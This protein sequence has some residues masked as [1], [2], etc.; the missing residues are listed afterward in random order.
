MLIP[1]SI[2]QE[3]AFYLSG[4]LPCPYLP[5]QT[6]R[7]LFARLSG[8]AAAN[9][10]LNSILTQA[11]FRR[12]HDVLYRPACPSCQACVPVRVPAAAFAPGRTQQRIAR[13]NADLAQALEPALATEEQFALFHAYQQAR[14]AASD[15]ARMPF[16]AYAAMV[17]DGGV[18]QQLLSLRDGAGALRGIMLVDR[19]ADGF[20]AIYSFFDPAAPTRSLGTALVLRLIA[21]AAAEKLPY[22]YL[23]YWIAA[24]RKMAYKAQFQPQERLTMEGWR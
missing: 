24:S 4:A 3:T 23:G 13:R 10:M 22:V 16:E 12:S 2:V 19:L 1:H 17:Q 21:Q 18:G 6:E 20:S 7:K 8:D 5:G 14:H 15:M 9:G 11:G